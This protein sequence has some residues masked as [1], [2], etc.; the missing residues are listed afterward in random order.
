MVG[1][2]RQYI[3]SVGAVERI[4]QHCIMRQGKGCEMVQP[5]CAKLKHG[6]DK[7]FS[8]E[9]REEID[10]SFPWHIYWMYLS[11][12]FVCV[13]F[14][15]HLPQQN[16]EA[17]DTW[18]GD[19]LHSLGATLINEEGFFQQSI[20]NGIPQEYRAIPTYSSHRSR[21]LKSRNLPSHKDVWD[22]FLQERKLTRQCQSKE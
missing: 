18:L 4:A 13:L 17:A 11:F 1:P 8:S 14:S 19:L 16:G 3:I 10:G 7:N 15:V 22:I 9:K 12:F 6:M 20:L 2:A 21:P 5:F